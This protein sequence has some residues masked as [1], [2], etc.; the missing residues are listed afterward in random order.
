MYYDYLEMELS[1]LYYVINLSRFIQIIVHKQHFVST[2]IIGYQQRSCH[3]ITTNTA[4]TFAV[5]QC[6]LFV[7][8]T[9]STDE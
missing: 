1:T 9:K 6:F 5:N 7:I 3:E 2:N 4:E 8:Q